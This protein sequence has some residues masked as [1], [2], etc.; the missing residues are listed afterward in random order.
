MTVNRVRYAAKHHGHLYAA[1]YRA[2]VTLHEFARSAQP[3]HRAALRTVVAE[4]TWS[5]LPRARRDLPA[6]RAGAVSGAIIVPAH[7]EAAVIGRT[8]DRLRPLLGSPHLDVVVAANGGSDDTAAIAARIPGVT[9]LDIAQASKTAALNAAEAV[10]SRWP[11]IYLDADI[12]V[13]ALAVW[14]TLDALNRDGALAGRPPYAW[15]LDGADWLVHAY[16]RARARL[17]STR[18]ALWGAGIYAL[19]EDGRARF[20]AFPAVVAD[21]LFVDQRFT[22][23]E[24]LIVPTDAV[25]VRVPRSAADLLK[26]LR[27]Q[28]RGSAELGAGTASGTLAELLGSIR[29]PRTLVDAAVYIGFAIRSRHLGGRTAD[30]WERDDSSRAD[31]HRTEAAR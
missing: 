10:T 31:G 3:A 17:S 4:Q 9:V 18:S 27:R 15:D 6:P 30:T 8:L 14:E 16:Y 28:S 11:R 21:D 13:T 22:S 23:D 25:R 5:D 29:G 1:L 12:D 20:G 24:K 2:V 19:S 26:V 7:N